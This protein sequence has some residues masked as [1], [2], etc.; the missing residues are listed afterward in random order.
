MNEILYIYKKNRYLR[1]GTIMVGF[2]VLVAI[3]AHVIAPF[4]YDE[5]NRDVRLEPPSSDHWFGTDEFGRDVFSRVLYGSRIALRVAILGVSIQVLIGVTL[6]LI[7]G[8]FGRVTDQIV[9]FLAD[10][11]WS[12]PPII[13]SM[14]VISII[15][16]GLD[17]T[18]IA[19]SV[20]SWAQYARVVR[21][22]TSSLKNM[23]FVE[24]ALAYNE[25]HP[26]ILFRYI[27]PNTIPSI[28]VLVSLSIPNT[29]MSTTA[30]SFLGLGAQPPSPDWGLALSS[31]IL[32]LLN[33]PWLAVF[34]G[35]ALVYTVF[36]FNL[37]GE[38]LRDLLD[39]RLRAR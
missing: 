22:K 31:S 20:V 2:L 14:A 15:G 33:A 23:A 36:A 11:T 3:F 29:I 27:L 38:G 34:P 28:I 25:S 39:P 1:M 5:A 24:T 12:L 30:L 6:G 10:L 13:M 19:I 32:Y 4:D 26:S 18:I 17:N 16:K 21:A 37:L 7:S 9:S 8:Y 35:I